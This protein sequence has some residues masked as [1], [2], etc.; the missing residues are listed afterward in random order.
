MCVVLRRPAPNAVD[1]CAP[2]VQVLLWRYVTCEVTD[3]RRKKT[4]WLL[5]LRNFSRFVTFWVCGCWSEVAILQKQ[6][7]VTSFHDNFILNYR[8]GFGFNLFWYLGSL[9]PQE[10]DTVFKQTNLNFKA[11][12]I[13]LPTRVFLRE[14]SPLFCTRGLCIDEYPGFLYTF[15]LDK[16]TY[17]AYD[18]KIIKVILIFGPQSFPAWQKQLWNKTDLTEI[19]VAKPFYQSF[20]CRSGTS[21]LF[22]PRVQLHKEQLNACLKAKDYGCSSTKCFGI[23]QG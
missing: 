7:N 5:T 14:P 4:A 11:R 6:Q 12:K 13:D 9:P 15:W 19:V 23:N 8:R 1:W 10:E 3:R 20:F 17:W 21:V 18:S 2:I 16:M 22:R